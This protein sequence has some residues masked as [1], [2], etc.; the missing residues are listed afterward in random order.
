MKIYKI[1][2]FLV[3]FALLSGCAP[4]QQP[5]QNPSQQT[6]YP[7]PEDAVKIALSDG[8]ITV[9]G[10]AV[11]GDPANA[12]YTA[13]DIIY[14]ESGKDFTYGEGGVSDAHTAEEAAAHTVVY[15]T[16][17]G[18]YALSGKLSKGQIAVDL[19]NEAKRDPDAV[20][21]LVLDGADITCTVAPAVIFYQVYECDTDWVAY[22]EGE[23]EE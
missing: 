22:D 19:G 13:N 23:A 2:A 12:V 4:Q 21:T 18:T 11:S 17:P 6:K 15:I 20:V 1:V 16:K 8:G 9:D 5:S 10:T 3:A 7:V 14:Y